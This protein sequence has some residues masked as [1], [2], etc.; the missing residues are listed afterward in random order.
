MKKNKNCSLGVST[1]WNAK[2]DKTLFKVL[3]EIKNIGFRIL[4]LDPHM[5][6]E[7]LKKILEFVEKGEIKVVSLH[8]FCPRPEYIPEGR[9]LHRAYL[10]S[11]NDV[12]ERKKAVELTKRTIDWADRLGA[13]FVVVHAGEVP[14]KY[15][16]RLMYESY[17]NGDIDKFYN[18]RNAIMAERKGKSAE[19]LEYTIESLKEIVEY[20]VKKGIIVGLENRFYPHE[21]PD[22]NEIGLI[23][24]NL[25]DGIGYWHDVGHAQIWQN[26]GYGALHEDFLRNYKP[27][28][29][30]LHD[31]KGVTDHWAPGSGNIDFKKIFSQVDENVSK[32]IEVHPKVSLP[33]L[34]EG[35]NYIVNIRN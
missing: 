2:K 15:S 23:I 18:L 34:K 13:K 17:I 30:H 16:P 29:L 24:E 3:E 7:E 9:N 10:I 19:Y 28:G 20:A 27:V 22:F 11:S 21:I 31:V 32:I 1:S 26:L 35:I 33:E 4:E 5:T 8:N 14:V 25:K 12:E 6:E